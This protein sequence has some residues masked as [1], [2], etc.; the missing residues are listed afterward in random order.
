MFKNRILFGLTLVIV[1]QVVVLAGVY[2]NA[3]HPLW[4][5]ETIRLKTVPI[6][7]RSLFRGNY[8][9]LNY[10]ISTIPKRDADPI[11]TPRM[12][13]VVYVRLKPDE[14]G[15]MGYSGI[16]AQKPDQGMFIRGRIQ[17]RFAG[18][19]GYRVKYGI[20]AYFAPK[21]KALELEKKLRQS[22]VAVIKV[23]PN[24]KAAL[25]EVEDGSQ[26]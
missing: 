25:L 3:M 24:G 14:K 17:N 1:F 20:E 10:D 6:D 12:H 9:R 5:G 4:T 2:L 15:L 23:T 16:S 18:N 11:F 13:E 26:H 22:A 19:S 21:K 7:P 8:A